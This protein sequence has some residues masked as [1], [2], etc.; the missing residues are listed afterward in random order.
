MP[1]A[2]NAFALAEMVS[3]IEGL[4]IR[5]LFD[6]YDFI[7]PSCV[8]KLVIKRKNRNRFFQF[9]IKPLLPHSRNGM[10]P[11]APLVV[12]PVDIVDDDGKALKGSSRVDL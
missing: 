8:I 9:G 3:V 4:I 6:K 11:S 12:E 1:S 10:S 5:A 2:F 7:A